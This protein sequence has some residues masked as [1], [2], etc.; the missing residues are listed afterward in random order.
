VKEKSDIKYYIGEIYTFNLNQWLEWLEF[1][2]SM[3]QMS[4]EKIISLNFFVEILSL[5]F[6]IV[7]NLCNSLTMIYKTLQLLSEILLRIQ[8]S[9][10]SNLFLMGNNENPMTFLVLKK[11][12]I[13]QP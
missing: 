11:T 10:D 12:R 4:E 9:L 1:Y 3:H 7:K 13:V 2:I 5:C 6:Y 8:L